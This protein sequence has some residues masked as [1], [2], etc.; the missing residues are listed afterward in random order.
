VVVGGQ[1]EHAT[2]LRRA[3]GIGVLEHVA[4]A[5]HAG[6]LAVPHAEHAVVLRAGE[7]ADLL[8][9]PHHRRAEVLVEARRE[10]HARRL[11]VLA[12]PPQ[13]QVE[14]TER[15]TA[16]AADEAGRVEARG[17]VAQFLHQRQPHQRLH[18][19]QVDPAGFAAVL[20]VQGVVRIH[21]APGQASAGRRGGAEFCGAGHAKL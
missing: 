5:I 18:A 10:L 16:I 12:R 7:Q 21:D 13:F 20:V 15:R 8:R 17:R 9:A 1:R 11:E 2:V 19:G 3:R 6:T 4:A 14:T